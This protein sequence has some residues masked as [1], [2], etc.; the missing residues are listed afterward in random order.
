MPTAQCKVVYCKYYAVY[1]LGVEVLGT[2]L[3]YGAVLHSA[4]PM[5][6]C[7]LYHRA[8][9]NLNRGFY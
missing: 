7:A 4:M 5:P 2:V 9:V 6:M 8:K 1:E 3:C